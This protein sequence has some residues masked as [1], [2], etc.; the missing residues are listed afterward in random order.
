MAECTACARP[1]PDATICPSCTGQAAT[2]LRRIPWLTEQLTITLTRQARLGDRNGPR[3]RETPLVYDPR[4]SVD[5]ETFDA[6]L[7]RWAYAVAEHRDVTV[8]EPPTP[9]GLS[10]WLLR[11]NGAAAQHPEAGD[12]VAELDAMVRAAE[13]TIDRAPDQ[14]CLGPCDMPECEAWLY[15]PMHAVIAY[16]PN[17]DC[18]AEYRVEDRRAW[19]LE[20]SVD[21]LRTAAQLSRELPWIAGVTI[22][23][24]RIN[25][26]SS[27][28]RLTRYLPGPDDSRA[29]RFRVGEVIDLARAEAVE[30]AS[31]GVSKGATGAA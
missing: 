26:W 25:Q 21:Q 5:L 3:S 19:L 27:R 11:W 28:D 13:R 12:Y 16:C 31:K 24:K 14:R 30:S 2:Y 18:D 17:P 29:P 10:R 9:A 8:D 15:V 20:Q 23:R 7:S 22:D 4:A 6:D 1:A